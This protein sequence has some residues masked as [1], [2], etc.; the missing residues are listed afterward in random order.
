MTKQTIYLNSSALKSSGNCF[1][2]LSRTLGA[3]NAGIGYRSMD[4]MM[5]ADWGTGFH[6]FAARY[7]SDGNYLEGLKEALKFVSSLPYE[8]DTIHSEDMLK[9]VIL[10]YVSEY[11]GENLQVC[12]DADRALKADEEVK[13][14]KISKEEHE[15]KLRECSLIEQKFEYPFFE[16]EDYK[17]ILFGVLDLICQYNTDI[18]IMD[19]KTT[20]AKSPE[21]YLEAYRLNPQMRLYKMVLNR[22]AKQSPNNAFLEDAKVVINGIFLSSKDRYRRSEPFEITEEEVTEFET[23]LTNYCKNFI[24]WLKHTPGM[25]DGLL[26]DVCNKPVYGRPCMYKD[27]CGAPNRGTASA[28]LDL[29]FLK[30]PY[31]P[32]IYDS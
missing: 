6:R 27:I 11:Q 18:C 17:I 5:A 4:P 30:R 8:L 28:L 20:T 23:S 2:A 3:T 7:Y 19:H 22:M 21:T 9:L 26:T 29:N 10:G 13:Y 31:N 25:R 14:G 16:D 12:Y 32:N 1:L 24:Y 15:Q